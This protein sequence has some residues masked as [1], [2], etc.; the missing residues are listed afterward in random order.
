MS[1]HISFLLIRNLNLVIFAIS[2]AVEIE[3]FKY[4][5]NK[6]KELYPTKNI[7]IRILSFS[8]PE[9][10]SIHFENLELCKYTRKPNLYDFTKT[11]CEWAF[12]DDIKI[13]NL[14]NSKIITIRK[15]KKG[16]KINLIPNI[17]TIFRFKLYFIGIRFDLLIGKERE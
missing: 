4:L 5:Y 2:Y 9:E 12:L 7:N 1:F 8:N 3:P 10:I 16:I 14:E 15:I 6:L 11:N 13:C 17:S